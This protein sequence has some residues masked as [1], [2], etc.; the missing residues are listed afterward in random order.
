MAENYLRIIREQAEALDFAWAL[1]EE[2]A[3]QLAVAD[4]AIE[5]LKADIK[6]TKDLL[7]G[8]EATLE[9]KGL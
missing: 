5:T 4:S 7:D 8:I 3:R 9:A 2:Q 1:I 6:N